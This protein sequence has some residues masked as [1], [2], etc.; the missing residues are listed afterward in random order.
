MWRDKT[1]GDTI[2][3][4]CITP[5]ITGSDLEKLFPSVT[6]PDEKPVN[7]VFYSKEHSSY[8][9]GTRTYYQTPATSTSVGIMANMQTAITGHVIDSIIVQRHHTGAEDTSWHSESAG[10]EKGSPVV[11]ALIGADRVLSIR[12]KEGAHDKEW[13]ETVPSGHYYIL[14]GTEF[15]KR[16]EYAFVKDTKL[17]K[18]HY[19]IVG[20]CHKRTDHRPK[21]THVSFR[22]I[23]EY[24]GYGEDD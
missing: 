12:T 23:A 9:Y 16:H 20:M 5:P 15:Q 3:V 18:K 8:Q 7:T 21:R 19:T 24:A 6:S 13:A 22:V 14:D 17:N 10:L 1:T 11:L 2:R 4:K